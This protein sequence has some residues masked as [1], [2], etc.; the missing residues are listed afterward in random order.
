MLKRFLD[1]IFKKD[2]M[3]SGVLLGLLFPLALYGIMVG[4][5]KLQGKFFGGD[6]H[7]NTQ[8]LLIAINAL[9]MRHFMIDRDQ[10]NVGKGILAATFIWLLYYVI[11]FHLYP[12][13]FL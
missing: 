5:L 6:F 13:L 10:E 12:E 8:L 1:K 2:Q 3:S 7:E 11:R 4:L 9:F